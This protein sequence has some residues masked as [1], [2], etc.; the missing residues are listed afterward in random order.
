MI[1]AGYQTI[2]SCQWLSQLALQTGQASLQVRPMFRR[3]FCGCVSVESSARRLD[4]DHSLFDWFGLG[5]C[6]VSF[7]FGSRHLEFRPFL[8]FCHSEGLGL[9][10]W[11]VL[12]MATVFAESTEEAIAKTAHPKIKAPPIHIPKSGD[13]DKSR[14]Q[15]LLL[16]RWLHYCI[17]EVVRS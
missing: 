17:L 8:V 4:L 3:D 1:A 14:P 11:A 15:F 10:I 2:S 16:A 13:Y 5:F 12:A 9:A 6:R 7:V